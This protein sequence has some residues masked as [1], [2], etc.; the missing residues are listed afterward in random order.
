MCVTARV[1]V[2]CVF[3]FRLRL[4][5]SGACAGV[6]FL[7]TRDPLPASSNGWH[8]C[9]VSPPD[10]PA[11]N[12]NSIEQVYAMRT[13]FARGEAIWSKTVTQEE[14]FSRYHAREKR[15]IPV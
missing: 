14:S 4:F 13:H 7:L 1:R 6:G 10:V 11:S 15:D 5:F 9:H 8:F 12:E 3:F 2:C